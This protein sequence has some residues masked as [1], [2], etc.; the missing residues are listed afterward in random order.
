MAR[1]IEKN[2]AQL[3]K[4]R[5]NMAPSTLTALRSVLTDL[6]ELAPRLMSAALDASPQLR[7]DD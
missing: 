5:R 7:P 1:F 6:S 2:D 3:M 4:K